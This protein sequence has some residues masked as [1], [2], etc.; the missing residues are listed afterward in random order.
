PTV[1]IQ[2]SNLANSLHALGQPGEAVPLLERAL[3]ITE[4][5]YSPNH[6]DVATLRNTLSYVRRAE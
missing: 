1:A 4:T 5:A 2:L 6:P 3:A